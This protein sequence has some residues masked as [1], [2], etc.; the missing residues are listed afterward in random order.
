M[1]RKSFLLYADI[2]ESINQLSADQAGKL[3]KQ[4][5]AYVNRKQVVQNDDPLVSL[6]FCMI[7]KQLDR[8]AVKYDQIVEKRRKAGIA[9]ADKRKQ[10]SA[11]GNISQHMPTDNVTVTVTGNENG[12]GNGNRNESVINK[13]H[14]PGFSDKFESFYHEYD[15]DVDKTGTFF[16]WQ[17]LTPADQIQAIKFLQAYQSEF[18]KGYRQ[19]PK[20]YLAKK[21]WQDELPKRKQDSLPGE[22]NTRAAG[23]DSRYDGNRFVGFVENGQS[24]DILNNTTY[25]GAPGENK[26]LV[27]YQHNP[28]MYWHDVV[29]ID[30]K[31]AIAGYN[32]EQVKIDGQYYDYENFIR[33]YRPEMLKQ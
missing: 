12:N 4:I 33:A 3:F 30:K 6:L 10:M 17:K 18:Q 32:D 24:F 31:F 20:N 2:E 16:E 27:S 5:V 11:N 19:H 8:D 26:K 7:K 14:R 21:R 23:S 28:T 9:S 22:K 15:Y 29:E 1:K 25:W 13:I